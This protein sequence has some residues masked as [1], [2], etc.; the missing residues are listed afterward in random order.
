[1]FE[2]YS[3]SWRDPRIAAC[4]L[5]FRGILPD[6]NAI[7]LQAGKQ[8]IELVVG[9]S[10]GRKDLVNLLPEQIAALPRQLEKIVNSGL[11]FLGQSDVT[12]RYCRRPGLPLGQEPPQL[13]AR[14]RRTIGGE[15]KLKFAAKASEAREAFHERPALESRTER[16]CQVSFIEL[17]ALYT[18]RES[19][20]DA[21]GPHR[22]DAALALDCL[23]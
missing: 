13:A 21:L 3:V 14:A 17:T 1:M 4:G 9:L 7:L 2:I 22:T 11:I 18:L 8:F 6:F 16:S 23:C 19:Y 15:D 20:P 12:V 10:I 5:R